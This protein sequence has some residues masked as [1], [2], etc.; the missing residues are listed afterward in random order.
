[1]K[2]SHRPMLHEPR[3]VAT[4]RTHGKISS[5]TD[6]DVPIAYPKSGS[7]GTNRGSGK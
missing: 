3:K 5:P 2:E 7:A 1:M 6:K 4:G